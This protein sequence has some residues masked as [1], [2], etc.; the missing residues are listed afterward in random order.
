[1]K[2]KYLELKDKTVVYLMYAF[3]IAIPLHKGL[4]TL[5]LIIWFILS[6]LLLEPSKIK[7]NNS[8][9]LLPALYFIYIISL[10]YSENFSFKYFEQKASF[11]V[12]PAIF[13][14]NSFKYNI[15]II[16]KVFFF[17]VIGSIVS[18]LYCYGNAFYN[19]ISFNEL[20][21]FKAQVNTN[22]GFLDSSI[23]GGNY[24]YGKHF[25]ILHHTTYYAMYL[26][27]AIS[28]L[29]FQKDVFKNNSIKWFCLFLLAFSVLQSSSRAG[30]LVLLIIIVVYLYKKYN[31]R[32]FVYISSAFLLIII[33]IVLI[34]NPRINNAFKSIINNSL[35]FHNENN[36]SSSL[37]LMTWDASLQV[38]KKKPVFGVGIGDAYNE[39][40]NEYR[41]KRY[42]I[43]YRKKLN[44]HNQ[45]F[46]LA[47]ECG[48]LAVLIFYLQ[49]ITL[50]KKY[51][52]Y[53]KK[54][55]MSYLFLVIIVV[56]SFFES[57]FNQY[58]GIVF[59]TFLFC[60][61]AINIKSVNKE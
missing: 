61:F 34:L 56:N 18:V 25:S 26:C 1:M 54:Y 16:N 10:F 49:L 53:K 30:F 45:Y 41:I 52:I 15:K 19:S 28:I 43:P 29:L 3:T 38:I 8:L 31:I 6:L 27:F 21:L 12:F 24:F 60:L 2:Y 50:Y 57:I 39:L 59:Y 5:I 42:I 14:M 4:S 46:Q 37:R 13:Y 22:T 35:T 9:L 47:V 44:A 48:I 51:L 20:I 33:P 55:L 7:K 11:I 17:F 32:L 36:D 40:K 23:Q 58:S